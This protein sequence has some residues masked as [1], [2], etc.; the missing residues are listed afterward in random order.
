[1]VVF[2]VRRLILNHHTCLTNCS[3]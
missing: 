2:A 3:F 1:M